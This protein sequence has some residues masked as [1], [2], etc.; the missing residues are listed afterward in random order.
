MK[1]SI[2]QALDNLVL[3]TLWHAKNCLSCLLLVSQMTNSSAINERIQEKTNNWC[4]R[5]PTVETRAGNEGS[6][7]EKAPIRVGSPRH[8][9]NQINRFTAAVVRTRLQL[10]TPHS[11][12]EWLVPYD[13]MTQFHIYLMWVNTFNFSVIVKLQTSRRFVSSSS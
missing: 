9:A 12:L 8:Y 10:Y 13:F 5:H 1:L 3:A 6:V 4:L 7:I 2:Y 11:G